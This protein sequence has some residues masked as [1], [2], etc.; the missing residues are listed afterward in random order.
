MDSPFSFK[1]ITGVILKSILNEDC[2]K[3]LR[4]IDHKMATNI[5]SL[6]TFHLIA[7]VSS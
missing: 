4:I 3:T 5:P 7:E 6:I 1:F 2:K